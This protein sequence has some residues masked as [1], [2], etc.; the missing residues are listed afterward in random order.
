MWLLHYERTICFICTLIE[1]VLSD[2]LVS[3]Y[4][5]ST[6]T[7]KSR[8]D[9]QL[10]YL[11]PFNQS[12]HNVHMDDGPICFWNC[13]KL[14]PEMALQNCPKLKRGLICGKYQ[15]YHDYRPCPTAT[16]FCRRNMTN[17][18]EAGVYV[19]V[20][21][22]DLANK[23]HGLYIVPYVDR[24][25]GIVQPLVLEKPYHGNFGRGDLFCGSNGHWVLHDTTYQFEVEKI[26]CLI[27]HARNLNHVLDLK[28]PTYDRI[29]PIKPFEVGDPEFFGFSESY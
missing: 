28:N 10:T 4:H 26:F 16:I 12:I 22:T 20:I 11:S 3:A 1:L 13:P 6:T 17:F 23:K 2:Q 14:Q 24:E 25:N 5:L 9:Q 21:A 15:I 27:V 29:T 19:A 18:K 8:D 7:R